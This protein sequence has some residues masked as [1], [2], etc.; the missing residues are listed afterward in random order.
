MPKQTATAAIAAAGRARDAAVGL[1]TDLATDLVDGL[2]KSDRPLRLK[3]AVVGTWLLLS[4]ATMWTACP[5]TGPTNSL[6]A[7]VRLQTTSVGQVVSVRNDTEGTIW[8]EVELILD[9]T[10]RYDRRRTIRPGHNITPRVE[11]FAK[12]GVPAPADLKPTRLTIQCD[13]GRVSLPLTE[14]R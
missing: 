12:D 13:Q 7:T 5:R 10:W 9:D 6:G 14:R 11:D 1:A 2:K 8:T 3:A 4:I